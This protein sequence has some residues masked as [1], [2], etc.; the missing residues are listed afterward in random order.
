[1]IVSLAFAVRERSDHRLERSV[2][3][4]RVGFTFVKLVKRW[5][6]FHVGF[7]VGLYMRVKDVI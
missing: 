7:M 2:S 4:G 3:G 1:M 5:R 6:D